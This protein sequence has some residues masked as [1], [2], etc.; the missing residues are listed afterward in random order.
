M[1]LYSVEQKSLH[2]E[3]NV[4]NIEFQVMFAPPCIY[5]DSYDNSQI[6]YLSQT[7]RN[8]LSTYK[9]YVIVGSLISSLQTCHTFPPPPFNLAFT[10]LT[11]FS[12]LILEISRSHTMTHHSR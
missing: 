3:R 1:I 5:T 8:S 10:I 2:S 6:Y 11:S 4:L 12:R 7:S 9:H